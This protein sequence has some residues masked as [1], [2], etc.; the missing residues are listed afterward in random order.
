MTVT[1]QSTGEKADMLASYIARCVYDLLA[2]KL[3][4]SNYCLSRD[5]SIELTSTLLLSLINELT[6]PDGITKFEEVFCNN[7]ADYP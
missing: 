7:G 5:S 3:E 4:Q 6:H 1:E 2:E